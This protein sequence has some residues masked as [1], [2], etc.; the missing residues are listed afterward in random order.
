MKAT[1]LLFDQNYQQYCIADKKTGKFYGPVW[2]AINT[3]KYFGYPTCCIQEGI[4]RIAGI[5]P[6]ELTFNQSKTSEIN[7]EYSGLIPCRKCADNLA[8]NNLDVSKLITKRK[9]PIPFP[10]RKTPNDNHLIRGGFGKS[11]QQIFDEDGYIDKYVKTTKLEDKVIVHVANKEFKTKR[12]LTDPNKVT[13][14]FEALSKE[15]DLSISDFETI[16][17]IAIYSMQTKD[18]QY[19]KKINPQFEFCGLYPFVQQVTT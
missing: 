5:I 10:N 9:C 1:Y 16:R 19:I 15:N 18:K 7:G 12:D 11:I 14:D 3:G 6:R 17:Q 13:I 8:K 2:Y 4:G